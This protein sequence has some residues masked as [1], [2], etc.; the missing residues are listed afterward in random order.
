MK[1]ERQRTRP[2][3]GQRILWSD[4]ILSEFGERTLRVLTALRWT[5]RFVV[6]PS[7]QN[8]ANRRTYF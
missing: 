2:S 8:L 7:A 1:T 3:C 6:E 5:L 4:G